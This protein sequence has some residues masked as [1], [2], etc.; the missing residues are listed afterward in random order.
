[1]RQ[2]LARHLLVK[3][4]FILTF[5]YL[6]AT[7]VHPWYISVILALAVF[8]PY[9]F[10]MVWSAMLGLTYYAY[11][12]MPY[13]ENLWLVAVEYIVVLAC[14]FGELRNFAQSKNTKIA[15]LDE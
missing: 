12:T 14:L 5:Y 3:M 8:T 13:Q 11:S 7:I 15:T 6:M 10:P 2:A 9:R 4:L 1:M